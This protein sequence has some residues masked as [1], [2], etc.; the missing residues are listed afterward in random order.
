MDLAENIKEFFI[1]KSNTEEVDAPEGFCPNCWGRLEYEGEFHEAMMAEGIDT[2]N[3]EEKKGWIQAYTEKNLTGIRLL[4]KDALL[5]CNLCKLD[6][7]HQN[8]KDG[9]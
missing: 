5:I 9:K 6:Y 4:K 8:K 1:Q 2:N 7:P 3:I